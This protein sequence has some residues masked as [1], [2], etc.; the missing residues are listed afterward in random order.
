L[1]FVEAMSAEAAVGEA[2]ENENGER[3]DEQGCGDDGEKD[4][5]RRVRADK[6]CPDHRTEN[7]ADAP[8]AEGEAY[9]L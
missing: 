7:G 2:C 5:Q 3:A 6:P 1:G 9:A 8:G 4:D